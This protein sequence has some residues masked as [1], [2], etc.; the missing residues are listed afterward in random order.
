MIAYAVRYNRAAR[1]HESGGRNDAK[2]RRKRVAPLDSVA[3]SGDILLTFLLTDDLTM[4][5]ESKRMRARLIRE[6]AETRTG[7]IAHTLRQIAD[8]LEE[9]ADVQEREQS[10]AS[11]EPPPR[12]IIPNPS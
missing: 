5:P 4:T 9:S 1:D 11:S 8:E 10:G 2:M 7:G 3:S 6:E 12:P